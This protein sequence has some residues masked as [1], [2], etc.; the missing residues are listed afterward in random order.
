M[1]WQTRF[2]ALAACLCVGIESRAQL[3]F[4]A[5]EIEINLSIGYAVQLVDVNGDNKLDIVAV[6]TDRILWYEN[7][8]WLRRTLIEGLTK[9]DN[10]AI[11][12]YDI[13]GDG[14][15][16]FA[17]AA[18]WRPADTVSSGTIQWLEHQPDG[19]PWKV[20]PIGQEPTA[21]RES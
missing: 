14:K 18:G 9:P 15:V 12:P 16:D 1:P 20:H 13:T 19:Q 3:T 17:L 11:A 2:L 8:T 21:H 7:P 5:Q 4:R 10:V 6:D